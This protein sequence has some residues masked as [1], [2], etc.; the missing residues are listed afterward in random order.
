MLCFLGGWG[1]ERGREICGKRGM[2]GLYCVRDSIHQHLSNQ[3]SGMEW[4]GV[5]KT[6]RLFQYNDVD[7]VDDNVGGY[8]YD[9]IV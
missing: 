5:F 2:V 3:V 8:Y 6:D 9:V 4:A 7:D 1:W